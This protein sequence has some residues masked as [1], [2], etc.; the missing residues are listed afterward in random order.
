[1]PSCIGMIMS[2]ENKVHIIFVQQGPLL[3]KYN[4]DLV[5]NGHDHTYARG[6]VP[7]RTSESDTPELGTVYVTSVSGPKQYGLDRKQILAYKSQ[8][9][10]GTLVICKQESAY[11]RVRTAWDH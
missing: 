1:M 3:D 5:L 11:D 10:R 2:I 8:G 9:Y 7:V 6:H 4:V